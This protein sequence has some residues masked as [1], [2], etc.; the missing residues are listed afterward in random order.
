MVWTSGR[1]TVQFLWVGPSLIT[2]YQAHTHFCNSFIMSLT[3]EKITGYPWVYNVYARDSLASRWSWVYFF[4]IYRYQVWACTN[5]QKPR[6]KWLY[7]YLLSMKYEAISRKNWRRRQPVEH[8]L[9]M[10]MLGM[11]SLGWLVLPVWTIWSRVQVTG[12]SML[13]TPHSPNNWLEISE[14]LWHFSVHMWQAKSCNFKDKYNHVKSSANTSEWPWHD[15][16]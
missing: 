1:R 4:V 13:R 15:G 9:F 5:P 16:F 2:V 8:A 11:T 6:W 14:V 3:W 10:F 7:S 12:R